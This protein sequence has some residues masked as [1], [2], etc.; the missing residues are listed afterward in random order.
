MILF[1]PI[2]NILYSAVYNVHL[3]FGF[4]IIILSF[5]GKVESFYVYGCLILIPISHAQVWEDCGCTGVSQ[6]DNELDN[7]GD[8]FPRIRTIRFTT[9]EDQ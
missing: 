6:N 7:R 1:V 5:L 9:R 8:M 2:L 4:S 3:N